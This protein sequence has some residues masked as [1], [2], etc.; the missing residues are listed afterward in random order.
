MVRADTDGTDR[1]RIAAPAARAAVSR[2][3]R[4]MTSRRSKASSARGRGSSAVAAGRATTAWATQR[5]R[6]RRGR[7]ERRRID[8]DVPPCHDRHARRRRR[9][10]ATSAPGRRS[11]VVSRGQE[12]HRRWP[13]RWRPAAPATSSSTA[14]SS[15]SEIPAPSLDAPSAPNA[16]R[17]A[18]RG[19][20]RPGPAAGPGRATGRPRPRRTR[21]HRH[22]AR[23]AAS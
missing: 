16:P 15:G 20:A 10:R 17:C 19:K 7:T 9:S 1:P 6:G 2:R 14:R 13:G 22:R 23:S 4:A 12:E 11:A 18:E 3:R 5:T 21:C 8:R